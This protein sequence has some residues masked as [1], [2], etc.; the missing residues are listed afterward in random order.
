MTGLAVGQWAL[1]GLVPLA[2]S[3]QD[4][5]Q[6]RVCSASL[7]LFHITVEVMNWQSL[8]QEDCRSL[9]EHIAIC[10][11]ST[12]GTETH[13]QIG[14][15]FKPPPRTLAKEK[16]KYL[17]DKYHQPVHSCTNAHSS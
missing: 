9:C 12:Q 7:A 5:M 15:I 6:C 3:L 17:L 13:T 8:G 16:H 14:P 11:K 1:A 10:T 2:G 4:R